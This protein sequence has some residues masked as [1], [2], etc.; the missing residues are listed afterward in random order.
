MSKLGNRMISTMLKN[1][2]LAEKELEKKMKALKELERKSMV[3]I[4]E[5]SLDVKYDFR[6]KRNTQEMK[7]QLSEDPLNFSLG[8]GR[9]FRSPSVSRKGSLE[10]VETKQGESDETA[11]P[12]DIQESPNDASTN[13]AILI[14]NERKEAGTE[15]DS[16]SRDSSVGNEA[17]TPSPCASPCSSPPPE[18]P[19]INEAESQKMLNVF[20][21]SARGSQRRRTAPEITDLSPKL[22]IQLAK[23]SVEIKRRGST[24]D[25]AAA[26][27]G[28][29]QSDATPPAALHTRRRGSA[30][31]E[32]L[33][34]KGEQE[35]AGEPPLSPSLRRRGSAAVTSSRSF[36]GS[37]VLHR[38]GSSAITKNSLSLETNEAL[39]RD[40]ISEKAPLSPRLKQPLSPL[41]GRRGS[42]VTATLRPPSAQPSTKDKA[43]E[44]MLPDLKTPQS[45]SLRRSFSPVRVNRPVSARSLSLLSMESNQGDSQSEALRCIGEND[46]T[47][48]RGS[49]PGSA[50]TCYSMPPSGLLQANL[51]AR[52]GSELAQ[53]DLNTLSSTSPLR[54]AMA[55]PQ[56]TLNPSPVSP[57]VYRRH[58]GTV[59]ALQDRVDDFLRTLAAKSS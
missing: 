57:N 15:H 1:E 31:I 38:R 8:R 2:K 34:I 21:Q 12:G 36:T 44:P 5:T 54:K 49:R 40:K 3:K 27:A 32:L 55:D 14:N 43:P 16:D 56:G 13:P 4:C 7:E 30:A 19:A 45:P 28:D 20:S 23:S 41:L 24:H 37:P 39:L 17:G 9:T 29:E 35:I 22:L 58:S 42:G 11:S 52:R 26:A 50:R 46:L 48:R 33:H 59:E 53:V 6:R 18:E 25:A 47:R 51:A 10:P